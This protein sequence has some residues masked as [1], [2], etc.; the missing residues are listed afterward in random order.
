MVSWT[1]DGQGKKEKYQK[2]ALTETIQRD[3][4]HRNKE[5]SQVELKINKH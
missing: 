4:L 1:G 3:N 5:S 2:I